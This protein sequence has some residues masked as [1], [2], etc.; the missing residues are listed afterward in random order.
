MSTLLVCFSLRDIVLSSRVDPRF[1]TAPFKRSTGPCLS[2]GNSRFSVVYFSYISASHQH[3]AVSCKCLQVSIRLAQVRSVFLGELHCW[4]HT[5]DHYVSK[6][7]HFPTHS[8]RNS[9]R[10]SRRS[11]LVFHT[12]GGAFCLFSPVASAAA[13]SCA[14][15]SIQSAKAGVVYWINLAYTQT[16]YNL[17]PVPSVSG[18]ARRAQS[19]TDSFLRELETNPLFTTVSPRRFIIGFPLS[20]SR[21]RFL[22]IRLGRILF[23]VLLI[24]LTSILRS[25]FLG[26]GMQ[27]T[28]CNTLGIAPVRSLNA[29]I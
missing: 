21:V 20:L 28:F 7:E 1:R 25:A 22:W 3:F 24:A 11:L 8:D 13:A 4:C 9:D 2:Q 23:F 16:I 26:N 5:S 10:I 19:R 6:V 14:W 12:E 27:N 15:K 17:A 18:K 29:D